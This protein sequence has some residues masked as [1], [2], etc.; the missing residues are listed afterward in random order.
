MRLCL[1][2]VLHCCSYIA[3]VILVHT[4]QQTQL[5]MNMRMGADF[6]VDLLVLGGSLLEAHLTLALPI[7]YQISLRGSYLYVVLSLAFSLI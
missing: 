7:Q 6:T 4:D 1:D 5:Q 3:T 2:S